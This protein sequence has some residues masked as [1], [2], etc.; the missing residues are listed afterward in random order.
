MTTPPPTSPYQYEPITRNDLDLDA[1]DWSPGQ[2][3]PTQFGVVSYGRALFAG[4]VALAP[5]GPGCPWM[6]VMSDLTGSW[7]YYQIVETD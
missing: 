2:H 4:M 7:A 6:A 1:I 5:P 3:D